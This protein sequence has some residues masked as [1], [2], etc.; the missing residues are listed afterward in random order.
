MKLN[1]QSIHFTASSRL[2]DYIQKKCDKLDHFFDRIIEGEVYLKL[3]KE[4]KDADKQVEIKLYVPGST[5]IA[6]ENAKT[7]EAATDLVIDK[8]KG[9]L[10][11]YKEK[12][13]AARA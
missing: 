6:K 12:L 8:L 10:V 5:L 3:Q 7:F 1:M 4:L 13:R 2:K 9:Q 11:R